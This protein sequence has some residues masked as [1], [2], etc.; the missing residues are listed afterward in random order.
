MRLPTTEVGLFI[1]L[2]RNHYRDLIDRASTTSRSDCFSPK[3]KLLIELKCRFRHY[4][5]LLIEKKKYDW[6]I[7][8]AT[9][10]NRALYVNST[11]EGVWGFYLDEIDIEWETKKMPKTTAFG[12][13]ES[14]D[15]E[16]GFIKIS[17]GF[18]LWKCL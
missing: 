2:R 5:T 9:D 3:S 13:N 7:S 11:P 14:I 18:D 17:D 10:G 6:L 4:P 16:I 12:S 1:F 8:N 15:K